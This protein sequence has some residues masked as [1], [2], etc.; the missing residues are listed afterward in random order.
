[1]A[2]LDVDAPE[3]FAKSTAFIRSHARQTTSTETP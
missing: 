1:V 2:T 3:I